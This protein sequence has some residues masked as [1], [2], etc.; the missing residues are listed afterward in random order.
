MKKQKLRP[1]VDR[2]VSDIVVFIHKKD[3]GKNTSELEK[4][5]YIAF[6]EVVQ[7]VE[8]ELRDKKL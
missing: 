5:L 3:L 7:A 4:R 6:G 8:K 2:A 1:L